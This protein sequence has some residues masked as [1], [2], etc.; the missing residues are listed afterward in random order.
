MLDPTVAHAA[1]PGCRVYYKTINCSGYHLTGNTNV[2][3]WPGLST[4]QPALLKRLFM[5]SGNTFT[6]SCCLFKWPWQYKLQPNESEIR[7]QGG[8]GFYKIASA[9]STETK[10]H[11]PTLILFPG[12]LNFNRNAKY[13]ALT[14]MSGAEDNDAIVAHWT[15]QP[16][17]G[18]SR[19]LLIQK[20]LTNIRNRATTAEMQRKPSGISVPQEYSCPHTHTKTLAASFTSPAPGATHG[21]TIRSDNKEPRGKG[22]CEPCCIMNHAADII[23]ADEIIVLN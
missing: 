12:D 22:S 21:G 11:S 20:C 1:S 4:A 17:S 13:G 7:S 10:P 23:L 8:G 19:L 14:G 2:L 5:T 9:T 18:L 6:T 16:L 3:K 15:M